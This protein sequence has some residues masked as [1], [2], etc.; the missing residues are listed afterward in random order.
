MREEANLETRQNLLD[1]VIVLMDDAND[2]S[3]NAAKPSHAVL[4]CKMEQ[5]EIKHYG[6][7]DKINR[8][9]RANVQ[10]HVN[11]S[12]CP[13]YSMKSVKNDSKFMPYFYFNEGNCSHTKNKN[14]E[15]R[16]LMYKHIC[17]E[18]FTSSCRILV[19][20]LMDVK[21][22]FKSIQNTKYE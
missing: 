4:L 20:R 5:G 19:F 12:Q 8:I 13:Q 21:T 10:R 3:W 11:P 6:E 17:A 15:T 16:G 9:P 18:C 22:N 1:C 14:H 2:L 7:V